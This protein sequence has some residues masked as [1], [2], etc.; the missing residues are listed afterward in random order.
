MRRALFI[1]TI[2]L[3]TGCD[4]V[5]SDNPR[6]AIRQKVL[7]QFEYVNYAWGYQHHGWLIDSSG[8]LHGYNHP[9]NWT[10]PDS[11]GT[12]SAADMEQNLQNTD[13]VCYQLEADE[14]KAMFSLLPVAAKGPISDPVPEMYDAGSAVYAGYIFDQS[15]NRYKRILL[16]QTGDIR[17]DN[18]SQQAQALYEWL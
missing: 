17:I 7:F 3:L 1:F 14:L 13:R 16:Q 11:S 5:P 15:I 2:L 10:F 4:H 12:I 9:N 18:Q 8:E 6:Y